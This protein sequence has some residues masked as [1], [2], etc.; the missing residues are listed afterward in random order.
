VFWVPI[1]RRAATIKLRLY[2]ELMNS[3]HPLRFSAQVSPVSTH[4][5][6]GADDILR[7]HLDNGIS[8][9]SRAN[10]NSPSVV[11]NGYLVAG[12]IFDPDEK[13]GLSGYTAAALMRG[14]ENRD[15][16]QIYDALETAGASLGI[17][18]GVNNVSFSGRALAEDLDLLLELL[19][20]VLSSPTFPIEH[21]ERLRAQILTGLAIRAQDTQDM[22]GLAFD[23]IVYAGHPYSRPEDGY[24]ETITAI[25]QTDLRAFHHHHYGPRG[26]VM[27]VVG[28]IDPERVVE[29]VSSALG[30]WNNP[31][32]P[33]APDLPPVRRLEEVVTQRVAIPE[34]SQSDIVVGAAGPSRFAAGYL[35]ASL[36]NSVLGQFG[37]MDRIGE[38]V[39]EK[40]GLAYYAHSSLS[41]GIGPGPWYVSAGVDPE[42]VER[43][44][45]LI[46]IELTRFV[47][48]PVSAEEL[49]DS[50]AQFV[51]SL[52][53][54]LESNAGVAAAMVSL[55]RYGLG[56]DYLRKYSDLIK[57]ITTEEVLDAARRYLDPDRLAVA[58]AGPE[59]E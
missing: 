30:D 15:F 44:V 50:Q 58:I 23:Q 10:F 45:E 37:M 12:G 56:L 19:A 31:H 28:A 34:K 47:R 27:S 24:P 20:D 17:G 42:N 36:G 43:A 48:E 25:G 38:A 22:S 53:L 6:P 49:S 26:L 9:L 29:K 2:S 11:I 4:S 21:V 18:G 35:A 39:R 8:V 1:C 13:L 41:G 33:E 16:Y 54:S 55:E 59:G 40:A 7:V 32:Q 3:R 52:P 14:T 5:L 46:R 57:A 51:G